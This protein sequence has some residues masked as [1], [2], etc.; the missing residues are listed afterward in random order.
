MPGCDLDRLVDTAALDD[1]EA[2]D[3]LLRL[4]ERAVG[5]RRL[6]VPDTHGPAAARRRELVARYPHPACLQIVEPGEALV[7]LLGLTGRRL[8]LRVHPLRVPA[9]QQH[10]LHRSPFV[11][12]Q[13]FRLYDEEATPGSTSAICR[14][15]DA[16]FCRCGAAG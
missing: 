2:A 5:D 1:V 4:G 14:S 15:P 11:V 9:N 10:E 6:A 7:L 3:D 16:S 13:R 12:E 8:L